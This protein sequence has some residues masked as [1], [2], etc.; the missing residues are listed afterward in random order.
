MIELNR[1]YNMDCLEGMKGISDGSVDAVICD[2]PY[3]ALNKGN[4]NSQWDR[5]LPFNRLFLMWK[6][7]QSV[8]YETLKMRSMYRSVCRNWIL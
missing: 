6:T 4:A 2:P 1:I 5:L 3:E 7:W 8:L